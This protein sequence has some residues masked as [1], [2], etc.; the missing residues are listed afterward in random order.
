VKKIKFRPLKNN[1][2]RKLPNGRYSKTHK[3]LLKNISVFAPNRESKFQNV[4]FLKKNSC[5]LALIFICN[6]LT[7]M[8]YTVE[9]NTLNGRERYYLSIN[10]YI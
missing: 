1:Y 3:K 5:F 8:Q 4:R 10:V 2:D 9:M 7:A 6:Y